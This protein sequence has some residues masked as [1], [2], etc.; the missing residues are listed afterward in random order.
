MHNIL[1]YPVG[2]ALV[3]QASIGLAFFASSIW[4]K[5]K[6]AAVF[7]GIQFALMLALVIAY[8]YLKGAGFFETGIGPTL[9][10]AIVIWFFFIFFLLLKK[11]G[12]NQQLLQPAKGSKVRNLIFFV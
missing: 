9:L 12:S 6:R 5:E 4:E 11:T 1:I 2:L 8:F 10:A 7:G 3:I